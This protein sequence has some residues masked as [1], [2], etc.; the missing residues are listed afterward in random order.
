MNE[1]Q[2]GLAEVAVATIS[3]R[4]MF[5]K[6]AFPGVLMRAIAEALREP[7]PTMIAAGTAVLDEHKSDET[8]A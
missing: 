1:M 6:D 7:T 8:S 4:A 2:K 3:S 5:P